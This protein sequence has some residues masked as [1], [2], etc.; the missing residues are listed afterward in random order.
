[1]DLQQTRPESSLEKYK[2]IQHDLGHR[3]FGADRDLF[4]GRQ[5]YISGNPKVLGELNFQEEVCWLPG[6]ADFENILNSES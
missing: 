2:L 4:P 3:K 6:L 1:M 5:I